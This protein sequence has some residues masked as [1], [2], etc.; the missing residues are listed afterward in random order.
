MI[1]TGGISSTSTNFTHQSSRN[2]DAKIDELIR[3]QAFIA[4]EQA[5]A[6]IYITDVTQ[7]R[8]QEL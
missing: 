4:M 3:Q 7:G 6:I 2:V 8:V 5:N 1:D